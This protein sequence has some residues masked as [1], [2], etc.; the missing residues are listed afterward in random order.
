MYQCWFAAMLESNKWE[1]SIAHRITFLV[2]MRVAVCVSSPGA[3]AALS[4]EAK[5]FYPEAIRR[6]WQQ[7][8]LQVK[9]STVWDRYSSA[10]TRYE[11]YSYANLSGEDLKA[12]FFSY[13]NVVEEK[14][15]GATEEM[16]DLLALSCLMEIEKREMIRQ[17]EGL[18]AFYVRFTPRR[19]PDD[20]TRIFLTCKLNQLEEQRPPIALG[21]TVLIRLDEARDVELSCRVHNIVSRSNLV[22]LPA[23]RNQCL[24][25]FAAR[26]VSHS[27][28]SF[29]A[30]EKLFGS[31]PGTVMCHVR[32][33]LDTTFFDYASCVVQ[34]A[35]KLLA[36]LIKHKKP[37]AQPSER[38]P[39]G[40][41]LKFGAKAVPPPGWKL[42]SH[43][44]NSHQD[45]SKI[46]C[47]PVTIGLNPEQ[48]LA[49]EQAVFGKRI[50]KEGWSAP[51]IIFGPPGTGKTKVIVEAVIQS[52][53]T[54]P[55][56]YL[57]LCAPSNSAADVLASRLSKSFSSLAGR[58]RSCP[59]VWLRANR[60]DGGHAVSHAEE[61]KLENF[62]AA[63]MLRLNPTSRPVGEVP[64]ELTKFCFQEGNYFATPPAA[65]LMRYRIIV[66]TCGSTRLLLEANLPCFLNNYHGGTESHFSHVMI[67]EASQALELE[68]LLSL[69][70]AS[71]KTSIV[72]TGDHKQLGP[73]VRSDF[74][75]NFG[76]G[77]SLLERKI[78]EST[79]NTGEYWGT[80]AQ[81]ANM[82][83][84]QLVRN[85]RSHGAL[86]SLPSSLF[87]DSKLE[88]HGE[89]NE[90]HALTHLK[91]LRRENF[92]LLFVGLKSAHEH[93]VDSPSFFNIVEA[94]KV[95]QLVASLLDQDRTTSS[96]PRRITTDD[97]AV[98]TPFRKQVLKLRFMFRKL[99][100]GTVR[101]GSVDDYQGQ[102]ELIVIISTVLG[103]AGGP[104]L[105][106][107]SRSLMASS[108]RF[109]VAITRAKAL[110]I[111]V[112]DPNAVFEDDCWRELLKYAVDAGV[113]VG[114]EQPYAM[115]GVVQEEEDMLLIIQRIANKTLGAA[116]S[117]EM[118]PSSLGF[119]DFEDDRPWRVVL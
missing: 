18:D 41:A 115:R 35:V 19:D 110:L 79:R 84:V 27:S 33:V 85:Y 95:C 2:M 119:D 13:Q 67:D 105:N 93:E 73:I 1:G 86:L 76:L 91:D 81:P 60:D 70:F 104:A 17:C 14:H 114:C 48:M 54:T 42:P 12:H 30:M 4:S 25:C 118:F 66:C 57:L 55:D 107:S 36:H 6:V 16:Y 100:L 29:R 89:K 11:K 59:P 63:P 26:S 87:Y 65:R 43:P 56:P 108:R 50:G 111:V 45:L 83:V 39:F 20:A 113:Y 5:P 69:T 40:F 24:A 77:K 102:E 38:S 31:N 34:S 37:E 103:S 44:V 78:M 47:N 98:I 116:N 10:L 99:N 3:I 90:T 7:P 97:I 92:P 101:V 51:C 74:C 64:A 49:V 88:E 80:H 62:L 9:S 46:H 8:A 21:D 28:P 52:L 15:G 75:R 106:A 82:S 94:D 112:G 53:L 117:S 23:S 22:L 71:K 58:L 72:V 96:G 109:N 61:Q 32:F 68:A